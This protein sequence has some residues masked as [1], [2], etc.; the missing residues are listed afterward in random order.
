MTLHNPQHPSFSR[1]LYSHPENNRPLKTESL[2]ITKGLPVLAMTDLVQLDVLE[3]GVGGHCNSREGCVNTETL[4]GAT[5]G[6]DVW[7]RRRS[8]ADW[9]RA[10][11]TL[12][13]SRCSHPP[14]REPPRMRF[15]WSVFVFL[16]SWPGDMWFKV[17]GQWRAKG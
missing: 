5:R 2:H 12:A 16:I 9:S 14:A 10:A 1:T 6:T 4:R 8:S 11:I 13:F 17:Y 3:L 7:L 15:R